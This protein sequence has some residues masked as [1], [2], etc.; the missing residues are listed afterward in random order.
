MGT[1]LITGGTGVVGRALAARHAARGDRVFCAQ[2]S[3][4]VPGRAAIRLD[5]TDAAAVAGV[6]AALRPDVIHHLAGDTVPRSHPGAARLHAGGTGNVLAAV[7]AHSPGAVVV[8]ASTERVYRG[9]GGRPLRESDRLTTQGAYGAT[10]AAADTMTRRR[11]LEH[12]LRAAVLR[13][14]HVYGPGDRVGSRLVPSL[15]SAIAGRHELVLRGDGRSR[16]DFVWAADVASAFVAVADELAGD[17]AAAGL[18]INVGGGTA[19]SVLELIASAQELVAESI[20]VRVAPGGA[21]AAE[22][23]RVLDLARAAKVIGWSPR[24]SLEAGLVQ[25]LAGSTAARKGRARAS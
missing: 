20:A 12:G 19:V 6:V 25:L 4:A 3:G 11:A 21:A 18:A 1:V 23:D 9:E 17:G 7:L 10:K 2:R 16:H 14:G 22:A 24:T 8:V 13:L 15:L 5:V